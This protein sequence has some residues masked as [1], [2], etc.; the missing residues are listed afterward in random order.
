MI[1]LIKDLKTQQ[2]YRNRKKEIICFTDKNEADEF[3]FN[4]KEEVLELDCNITFK[5]KDKYYNDLES[6]LSS[7]ES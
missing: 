7:Y 3:I 1:Y 2:L 6:L 5:Y 4:G